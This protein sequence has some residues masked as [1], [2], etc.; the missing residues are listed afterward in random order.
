MGLIYSSGAADHYRTALGV[1]LLFLEGFS[2]DFGPDPG[3]IAHGDSH[4]W[5]VVIAHGMGL[6]RQL[7]AGHIRKNEGAV[8]FVLALSARNWQAALPRLG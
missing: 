3:G 7:Y 4:E 5:P 6:L 8:T 2:R 1:D